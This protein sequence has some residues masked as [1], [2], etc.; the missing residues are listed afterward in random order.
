MDWTAGWV[1]P[2]LPAPAET[3]AMAPSPLQ[4]PLARIRAGQGAFRFDIRPPKGQRLYGPLRCRVSEKSGPIR[5]K[6]GERK[7]ALAKPRLPFFMN[8]ET[9]PGRSE[10]RLVVDFYLCKRGGGG[11]CFLRADYRQ[12]ILE[13]DKESPA[14]VVPVTIR[15]D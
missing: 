2:D 5:F 14:A 1:K 10:A 13:A 11:P 15:V 4:E 3:I 6:E 7:F 9:E 8:F 12:V